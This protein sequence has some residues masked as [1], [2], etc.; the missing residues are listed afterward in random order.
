[1]VPRNDS[2][3]IVFLTC[4]VSHVTILPCMALLFKRRW[5]WEL[6]VVIGS[7]L[8]SFMYHACQALGVRMFLTELQ[9]HRIDNIFAIAGLGQV[10]IYAANFSDPTLE[11][12]LKSSALLVGIIAQ[13]RDPWNVLYTVVPIGF[14]ASIPIIGAFTWNRRV[15]G[16][17]Y[18]KKALVLGIGAFACAVPF[19]ILGL[20]DDNDPYRMFHGLWHLI[21]GVAAYYLW[22]LVK[23]PQA[24]ALQT[25]MATESATMLGRLQR[26]AGGV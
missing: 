3:F 18:D 12:S 10:F 14:Y 16:S 17:T 6:F 8:S 5:L 1:M 26:R 9:W 2:P 19:F 15:L 7:M 11:F 22:K 24:V 23:N 4:V 21:G 13:E 25:I 20:D